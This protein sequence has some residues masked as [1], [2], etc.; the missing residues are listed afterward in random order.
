MSRLVPWLEQQVQ[1][2]SGDG[3]H[4]DLL[5]AVRQGWDNPQL[6]SAP[7][8]DPSFDSRGGVN[9]TKIDCRTSL[10][11]RCSFPACSDFLPILQRFLLTV[12]IFFTIRLEALQTEENFHQYEIGFYFAVGS[13]RIRSKK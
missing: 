1:T 6:I 8:G 12:L 11:T 7:A 5:F 10:Y 3:Q 13:F 9:R 4:L 2:G